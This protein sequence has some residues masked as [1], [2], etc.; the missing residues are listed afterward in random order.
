MSLNHLIE[1]RTPDKMSPRME[2]TTKH[3]L[4]GGTAAIL[5]LFVYSLKERYYPLYPLF[6]DGSFHTHKPDKMDM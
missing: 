3:H 6:S 1:S 4:I 2:L 5:T